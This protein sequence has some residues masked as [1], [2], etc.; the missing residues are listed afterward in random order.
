MPVVGC[1]KCNKK[2][3]LADEMLGKTV[4]CSSCQTPF[5]AGAGGKPKS[6]DAAKAAARKRR[7]EKPAG[8][9][10]GMTQAS[11][12]SLKDVGLSGQMNP[13]FD[14]F[15]Q[16]IPD[17]R[18][19]NPLG[20]YV[21]EDPGF[22]QAG[23]DD[24]EDEDDRDEISDDKKILLSN[25]ALKAKGKSKK[26]SK[27]AAGKPSDF[28]EIGLLGKI[29][30][31]IGGFTIVAGGLSVILLLL[32]AYQ[33]SSPDI[34][35]IGPTIQW[36]ALMLFGVYSAGWI[37]SHIL[38]CF[39]WPMAHANT[40]ALGA[41]GQKSSSLLMALSWF[42]PIGQ[43]ILPSLGMTETFKASKRPQGTKWK[44]SKGIWSSPAW[45]IGIFL[46]CILSGLAQPDS[47]GDPT[48]MFFVLMSLSLAASVFALF[49]MLFTAYKVSEAQH[50]HF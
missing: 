31:G 10:D 36:V 45:P 15:S 19:A 40:K 34:E 48:V 1:P 3:K 44:K 5:K 39:F 28:K 26:K 11:E 37:L 33:S 30:L 42:I 22:G 27:R 12:A 23:D 21:L 38:G 8:A 16:P 20:N 17:K 9:G 2:Y 13:Q 14:L 29:M 24:D 35:I 25:P 47:E 41:K 18:A 50:S 7:R 4:R 43:L 46:T 6:G 49:G 32:G